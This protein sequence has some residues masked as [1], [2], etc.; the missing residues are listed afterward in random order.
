M[1]VKLAHPQ[2]SHDH[3]GKLPAGAVVE[4]DDETAARWKRVGLLED[5][6]VAADQATYRQQRIKDLQDEMDRLRAQ[7]EETREAGAAWDVATRTALAEE[8]GLE[9]P[10]SPA[11]ARDL[12]HRRRAREER[13]AASVNR[14]AP[15]GAEK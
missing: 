15:K 6:K 9:G 12:L 7:E 13:E 2:Y 10:L 14:S 3:G 1:K 5:E 8:K 4:V 11:Q